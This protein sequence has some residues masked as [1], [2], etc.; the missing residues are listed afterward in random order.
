MSPPPTKSFYGVLAP[1]LAPRRT[2]YDIDDLDQ[3]LGGPVRMSL[4]LRRPFREEFSYIRKEMYM[5]A[6]PFSFHEHR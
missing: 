1:P 3:M 4:L 6:D 5:Q 2:R